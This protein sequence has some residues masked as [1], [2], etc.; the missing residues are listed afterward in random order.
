MMQL[1]SSPVVNNF[2]VTL[3]LEIPYRCTVAFGSDVIIL[4]FLSW[5]GRVCRY[6]FLALYVQQTVSRAEIKR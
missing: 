5:V 4:I 6:I 1:L 3:H 2:C